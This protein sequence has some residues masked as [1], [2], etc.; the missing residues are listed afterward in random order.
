MDD[1]S[2]HVRYI[3]KHSFKTSMLLYN[4]HTLRMHR[5]DWTAFVSI[6][7][8]LY[9][10]LDREQDIRCETNDEN[11]D[12]Y[13]NEQDRQTLLKTQTSL[14]VSQVSHKTHVHETSQGIPPS[15]PPHHQSR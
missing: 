3:P 10:K 9:V 11:I 5:M 4:K 14:K 12:K 15:C 8:N 7:S 1:D 6:A 2:L 13:N